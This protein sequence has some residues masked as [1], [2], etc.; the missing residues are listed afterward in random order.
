M[1]APAA[2]LL[3][4]QSETPHEQSERPRQERLLGGLVASAHLANDTVTSMLPA[5]LPS[6]AGRFQLTPSELAVLAG[7]FAVSTSL[8]Q[9]LF[10]SLADRFGG[11]R[12]G[13]AGLAVSGV[14]IASLGFVSSLPWL[15]SLLLIGGLGSSALHPAGLGLARAASV[16]NPGL[17]VALFD[18]AGMAGG[19]S[20]PLLV[21]GLTAS[22]GPTAGGWAAVPALM[23]AALLV[24]FGR[25]N[26]DVAKVD[27]VSLGASLQAL[28]GSLGLL[29]V[30]ALCA[31][32]VTL[33]FSSAMPMWLVS[34]RGV[35]PDSP[36][37]GWT[38]ATFWSA[39]AVGGLAGASLGRWLPPRSI[40][41]G[42]L[43]LA[44]LPL[45]GILVSRPGSFPY[46][47]AVAAAG[48]LICAQAPLVMTRAQESVA[49]SNSAVG[50]ILLG[51]TMAVAAA[52]YAVLGV[53][54]AELGIGRTIAATFLVVLPA[55][56]IAAWVLRPEP[57]LREV[58]DARC[59]TLCFATA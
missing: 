53:A 28:R 45:E 30:I 11:H 2:R 42:S 56:G 5:L 7:A 50:G 23:I 26:R 40:V 39:A 21:G 8:P 27:R 32:V 49:G 15:C 20:G 38:L 59:C 47:V 13:A 46:F 48:A 12:I 22:L 33:T 10:G 1:G 16:K 6:I 18:A 43:L 29:A 17:G 51:A 55:A 9:P 14:L 44:L 19:A 37:I 4:M 34:E 58:D 41:V 52:I 57:S 31:N 25:R 36:T 24:R 3:T 54:Q 35:E